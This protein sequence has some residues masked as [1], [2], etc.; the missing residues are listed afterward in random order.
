MSRLLLKELEKDGMRS[1]ANGN[2]RYPTYSPMSGNLCIYNNY[3]HAN[4]VV[5]SYTQVLDQVHVFAITVQIVARLDI[6]HKIV[7]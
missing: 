2:F 4:F 5:F 6:S 3:G 7:Q 1:K